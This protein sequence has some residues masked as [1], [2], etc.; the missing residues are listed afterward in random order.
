[1]WAK[2]R[3]HI[4]SN[5]ENEQRKH[6]RSELTYKRDYGRFDLAKLIC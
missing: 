6:R 1:M 4:G 5:G 2:T 3:M